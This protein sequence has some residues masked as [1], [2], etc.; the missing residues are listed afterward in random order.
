MPWT[1]VTRANYDRR[2]GRPA[3][4]STEEEWAL[5]APFMPSKS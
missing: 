3:S 4:D 5:V 1:E 2:G